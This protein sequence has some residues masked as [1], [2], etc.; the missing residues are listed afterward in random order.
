LPNPFNHQGCIE[1]TRV[2][3]SKPSLVFWSTHLRPVYLVVA[4]FIRDTF[5]EKPS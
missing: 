2:D 4:A 3:D 1:I 5:P